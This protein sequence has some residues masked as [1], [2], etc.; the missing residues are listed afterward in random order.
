MTPW[1]GLIGDLNHDGVLDMSDIS[2]AARAFGTVS[3]DLRWNSAADVTGPNRVL[4]GKV[5][6][7]DICLMAKQFGTLPK[8]TEVL[9]GALGEFLPSRIE[10]EKVTYGSSRRALKN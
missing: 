6:M 5:D 1:K 4:D 8:N 7:R 3:G 9:A 2:T 10:F